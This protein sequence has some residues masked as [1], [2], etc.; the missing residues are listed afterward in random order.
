[1]FYVNLC[2]QSCCKSKVTGSYIKVGN[3]DFQCQHQ[4]IDTDETLSTQDFYELLPPR[5]VRHATRMTWNQSL[6]MFAQFITQ[7]LEPTSRTLKS[8]N[9]LAFARYF[10]T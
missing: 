4:T 2:K 10:H 6:P 5:G 7:L 1:M 3:Y 9:S 8:G